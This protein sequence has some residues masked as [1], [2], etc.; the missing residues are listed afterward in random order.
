MFFDCAI[1]GQL[2][3]FFSCMIPCYFGLLCFFN[4]C[5]I[6]IIRFFYARSGLSLKFGGTWWYL[7]PLS[8]LVSEVVVCGNPPTCLASRSRGMTLDVNRFLFPSDPGCI[9]STMTWV[10]GCHLGY[11]FMCGADWFPRAVLLPYCVRA[12]WIVGS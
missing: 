2:C 9:V 7:P 1:T 5:P 3:P 4:R 12:D 11:S 10:F 8:R 6:K